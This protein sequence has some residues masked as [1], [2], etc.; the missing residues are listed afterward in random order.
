MLG[1]KIAEIQ[2]RRALIE[3]SKH[4]HVNVYSNSNV[5]DLV[6]VRYCGSVDYWSEMPKVFS[7]SRI[8]LNFTIPNIKSGIPLRIWDILGSGGFLMTNFQAELPLYFTEGEDLVCFD[9]ID[10]LCEK[11][12]YYLTHEDERLQIAKNGY[13]KGEETS[14]L[15]GSHPNNSVGDRI[16]CKNTAQ[17]FCYRLFFDT[18][19]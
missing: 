4:F 17:G 13:E 3:L 12:N 11:T 16:G 8:N 18:F 9:G 1:F 2:R 14:Q 6:R 7:A 19:L 10:D 5:S 15:C